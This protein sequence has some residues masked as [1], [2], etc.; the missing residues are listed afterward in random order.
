MS[1]KEKDTILNKVFI[2]KKEFRQII[3]LNSTQNHDKYVNK[4]FDTLWA[5]AEKKLQEKNLILP[6]K[7]HI[8]SSFVKEYLKQVQGEDGVS[9]N[10]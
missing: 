5:S 6:D 2:N 9:E 7:K 4:V 1:K 8:P 10:E 3:N